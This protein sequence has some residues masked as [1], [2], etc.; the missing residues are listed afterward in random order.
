MSDPTPGAT[1]DAKTLTISGLLDHFT[2]DT[3][4]VDDNGYIGLGM[5]TPCRKHP[6]A[7]L[8]PDQKTHNQS[9]NSIRSAVERTI[10]H[11]KSW[12]ILHTHYRR[13]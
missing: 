5:I 13:P 12:R 3:P 11:L 2:D 9:V 4:L 7:K 10:A 1:R 6:G 8:R